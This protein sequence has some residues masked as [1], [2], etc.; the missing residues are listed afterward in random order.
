M[1]IRHF[2]W[3]VAGISLVLNA[4]EPLNT[5]T[6]VVAAIDTS[7]SPYAV[8][9]ANE[10]AAVTYRKGETVSV[11]SPEGSVSPLVENPSGSGVAAWIPDAG[12]IYVLTNSNSGIAVFS[13]RYSD[14]GTQGAGTEID[15]VK[16]MDNEEISDLVDAGTL[17]DGMLFALC[18]PAVSVGVSSSPQ[19][20]AVLA[21][22]GDLYRIVAATDGVLYSGRAVASVME[23]VRPGPDRRIKLR[24]ALAVAYSGDA[25]IGNSTAPSTLKIESPSGVVTEEQHEGSGVVPFTPAEK[26]VW[27]VTLSAGDSVMTACLSVVPR[28]FAIL[29]R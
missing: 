19:G 6:N 20:Y 29:I 8:L 5:S 25:W 21:E 23:T 2:L 12:G 10:G 15:P 1:G 18:G 16:I 9:S 17:S 28:Q 14:F 24:D 4:D 3:L 27:K 13:V 22:D 26:G 7:G 11:I